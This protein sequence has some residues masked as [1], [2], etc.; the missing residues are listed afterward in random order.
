MIRIDPRINPGTQLSQNTEHFNLGLSM[1][2]SPEAIRA[3]H[4]HPRL[5]MTGARAHIGFQILDTAPFGEATKT[6]NSRREF[7]RY[8]VGGGARA[9]ATVYQINSAKTR[10][11]TVAIGAGTAEACIPLKITVVSAAASSSGSA[12]QKTSWSATVGARNRSRQVTS[13]YSYTMSN[14]Y[15]GALCP[16]VVFYQDG[17]ASP[18]ARRDVV[19]DCLVT[20]APAFGMSN[21]A[22]T[23]ST[24]RISV[25]ARHSESDRTTVRAGIPC[26]TSIRTNPAPHAFEKGQLP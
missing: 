18:A 22:Y 21:R 16:L 17:V 12:N 2:R 23:A 13:A 7:V 20:N 1:R 14:H 26:R 6:L 11:R 8:Q 10:A 4:A 19:D 3:I 5:Q 15:S 25:G 24:R 9:S